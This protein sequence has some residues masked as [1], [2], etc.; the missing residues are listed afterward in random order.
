VPRAPVRF[1]VL[2][3]GRIGTLH[4]TLL[5]GRVR[6]A[7]LAAVADVEP[8]RARRLAARLGAVALPTEEAIGSGVDAVAVCASTEVQSD[9]VV[10]AAAAGRHVFCEKP[11]AQDVSD[12]DRAI[13]ATERAGVLLHVGFNR[14]FD[15]SHAAVRKAVA[16]GVLGKLHLLRITSR[17]PEPPPPGYSVPG[18]ILLDTTLHDFDMARF[19]SGSEIVDV[20]VRGAARIERPRSENWGIDTVVAVVRHANGTL[21]TIDNSWQAVYGYDQRVEAFGSKGMATSGHQPEHQTSV[22]GARGARSA[23]LRSFFAERYGEAYERQWSAFVSAIRTGGPA[24]VDG[25]SAR[26]A[27]IVGLAARRSLERGAPVEVDEISRP[28]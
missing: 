12:V 20:F 27:L 17:D 24:P 18:G 7:E 6:G 11:L 3:A 26:A 22:W 28:E 4:A 15:P 25:R 10:A 23:R 5:A 1:A 13:A 8:A 9:L 19:V 16:T 21:T 14:R 2:G